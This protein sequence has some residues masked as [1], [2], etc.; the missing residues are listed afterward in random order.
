MSWIKENYHIAALGG[1]A[2]VL[3]GLGYLG[4]SSNQAVNEEF[5]ANNPTKKTDTTAPGGDIATEVLNSLTQAEPVEYRPTENGRPVDLFTSV[6]LY[7]KDGNQNELLDILKLPPVHEG[8]PNQWWVDHRIDPSYSDSPQRDQDGDGFTNGEEFAA[9]TDP[10]DPKKHG[11]LITKLEVDSIESDMWLL[12][13][14]SVLGKGYQ[15]DLLFR[16][17]GGRSLTNRLSATD[18][19]EEGDIFFKEAPGK[20]RFKLLKIESREEQGPTG[21][22]PRDWAIIEDQDPSKNGKKYEMPYNMREAKKR[23]FTQ[24]DHRVNFKLN[25]V[26]EE[27]TIFKVAE[28]GTFSLPSGGADEDKTYKLVD[29]ILEDPGPVVRKAV[30]VVVSYTEGTDT[31]TIEIDVPQAESAPKE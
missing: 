30:K 2:L 13:F 8:I 12:L 3:A 14:K 28:N 17:F 15:F 18:A 11:A 4:L 1:G 7:T 21:L 5:N 29:V 6:D 20:D 22:R 26:G 25:A 9:K 19:A 31:K 24:Y 27:G 10:N 16:P 23:L